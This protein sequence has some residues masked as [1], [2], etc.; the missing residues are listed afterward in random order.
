MHQIKNSLIAFL[1]LCCISC[2][3][4]VLVSEYKSIEYA[5]WKANEK[6][7]F[8]FALND[9][10]TPKNVFIN[11]RNNNQY[12]FSNLFIITEL[13]SP[14][15]MI[16]VDTL[17]YEMADV[18]GK[19]LGT[20]TANLKEN[21]LFYKENKIFTAAGEYQLHIRQ[22]MRKNGAIEPMEYLEGIQDVG[23]SIEKTTI[24]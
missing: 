12:S 24:E 14:D 23:F 5:K 17:Q 18:T 6:I 3:D 2:T 21:K 4:N 8:S 10:I 11:I 15:G 16:I 9:T 1:L 22:A 20:G 7:S 13:F 19:Y